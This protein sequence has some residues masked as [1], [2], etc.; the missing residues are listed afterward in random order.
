MGHYHWRTHSMSK[1]GIINSTYKIGSTGR[2][3]YEL[4]QY[5]N[6]HSENRAIAF[7]GRGPKQNDNEAFN[8]SLPL[9]VSLHG[10]FS[11]IFDRTGFYSSLS[12][13][14]LIRRMKK[15]N[16][17]TVILINLHGYYVNIKILFKYF[18]EYKIKVFY[19]LSDCWSFTGHCSHFT[20]FSC[21]KWKT[22]C[23]KCEHLNQ[24]PK[25]ILFDSSKQN[26]RDKKKIFL[27]V[28]PTLILP[29]KWLQTMVGESFFKD[30]KSFVI[31]NGVDTSIFKKSSSDFKKTH[32]IENKKVI[33][34][35]SQF[36]IAKKGIY[37]I[38]EVSKKLSDEFVIVLVGKM[39]VDVELPQNIIHIEQ[40]YNVK[41]IVDIYSSS[42]VLFNPTYEDTYPT[43][44]IEAAA[45]ELPVVCY[46]TGGAVESV[47][48][49]YIVE[50]GD[51]KK[52]VEDIIE[53]SSNKN[54]YAFPD[55]NISKEQTYS[56]Y[57]E[58]IS[59]KTESDN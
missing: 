9:S 11:R 24:Y 54:L 50:Q 14:R 2:I 15:E 41:E 53:L 19:A 12:T 47:D 17:D 34:C 3:A 4:Q 10:V 8:F 26:Y 56:Q 18:K 7:Y 44:N 27:S 22:G 38:I 16:I 42:D 35:I 13:K 32:N 20:I 58:C 25:S 29:C 23:Y 31:R 49:N 51:I 57:L 46:K 28:N 5:I 6:C 55:I 36:W 43:V 40:T 59:N 33:L 48:P 1:I 37:D 21:E 45:C 39:N 52:S 30:T